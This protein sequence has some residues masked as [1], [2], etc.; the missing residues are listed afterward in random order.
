MTPAEVEGVAGEAGRRGRREAGRDRRLLGQPAHA[1][2]A[3]AR[4]VLVVRRGHSAVLRHGPHDRA[5]RHPRRVAPV[6]AD[7]RLGTRHGRRAPI[8]GAGHG[9]ASVWQRFS[10]SPERVEDVDHIE[11]AVSDCQCVTGR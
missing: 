9:P 5:R 4:V 10:W 11:H 6:G 7:R 1:P 2:A 3:Q 8:V